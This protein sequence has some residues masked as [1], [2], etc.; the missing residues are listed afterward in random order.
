MSK[1]QEINLI[2]DHQKLKNQMI[3]LLNQFENIDEFYRDDIEFGKATHSR[4]LRKIYNK[5]FDILENNYKKL[6]KELEKYNKTVL[7]EEKN[8]NKTFIGSFNNNKNEK[9]DKDDVNINDDLESESEID[10]EYSFSSPELSKMMNR[11]KEIL[12]DDIIS[13]IKLIDDNYNEKNINIIIKK[14]IKKISSENEEMGTFD[15]LLSLKTMSND[16]LSKLIK[17][18]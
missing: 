11:Q 15:I 1:N 2:F 5:M 18:K 3:K 8:N 10:F 17:L 12:K 16:D 4:N 13:K 14:L 6:P 9:N 7:K